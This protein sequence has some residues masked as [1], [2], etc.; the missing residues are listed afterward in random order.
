MAPTVSL[1][2]KLKVQ[3]KLSISRLRMVQQK[4][5]A[6]VKQQ[7]RDM[8]QLIEAGK[9]QSARIRVENI[10]RTDITT[11]LHEILELYCEL[12]LAR[13][14]LLESQVSSS[15]TTT[16]ATSGMLDPA[17]EEAVRSIIYA[18]PRTE[19]KE[20]HTV[21]ALLVEK[22]GKEVALASMEGEGVAERVVKKLRVETPK[23][24]LVEAYMA[25]IAKFYGKSKKEEEREALAKAT[26]PK[27]L[28]PQSPLRVVPPSPST[29]NVAPRLK[30]PGSAAA[31]IAK[32]EATK[33][34]PAKKEDGLGK[35]PDVDELARRFAELKR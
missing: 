14:Q 16:S 17:L 2:N 22:F 32:T 34:P 4:D 33:K 1:V 12:L 11:E 19:I 3:L 29:D 5:S 7:R 30:L 8:A 15:N 20:L 27:K 10:I 23:E 18:A 13:S 21:R 26:T 24:E 6:K 28:G 35:I 9:V 25:E 31:K